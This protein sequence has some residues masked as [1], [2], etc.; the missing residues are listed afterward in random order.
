MKSNKQPSYR[1]K[2]LASI[3]THHARLRGEGARDNP[4][5]AKLSFLMTHSKWID[6]NVKDKEIAKD[7][8]SIASDIGVA[9]Y[10]QG[11]Q[12]ALEDIKKQK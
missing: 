9:G 12:K 11:Y 5:K 1:G 3:Y 2:P 6:K 7:I 8:I 10:E 4:E